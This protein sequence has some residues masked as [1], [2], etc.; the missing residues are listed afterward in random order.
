MLLLAKLTQVRA[1]KKRV[2]QA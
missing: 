2:E 1:E